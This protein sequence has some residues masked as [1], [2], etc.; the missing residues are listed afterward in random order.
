MAN[1]IEI[2]SLSKSYS[3]EKISVPA[4]RD[5]SLAIERGDI[6]GI[7]GLSG[8]GKSTLIRCLASLVTPTKGAILYDGIDIAKLSPVKLREFRHH[9]GMIFQHFNLLGSRTVAQNVAFPLEIIGVPK[10]ERERRVEDLL[11]L[12]GLLPKTSSYA[13]K[14]SGGEKQRVGIARALANN[15]RV[16]FCDEATS[17]LDP[18]TTQEILQLLKKINEELGVTIVLITHEMEVIK[19]IC[20]KVAVMEDGAIVEQ[21]LVFDVFFDPCHKTTREFLS[22]GHYQIPQDF[23]KKS[24]RPRMLLRLRY[25]GDR[26]GEATISHIVKCFGVDAN[27]ILGWVDTLQN[28]TIGTLVIELCGTQEGIDGAREYLQKSDIHVEVLEK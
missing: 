28:N 19:Q 8:A 4:I 15:P 22:S 16:L 25:R 21:G 27:I 12:V 17:A 9:I 10:E 18:R 3:H 24:S 20:N 13:S 5:I 6:F 14:L 11:H 26:T 7:I 23:F 1:F 2:K